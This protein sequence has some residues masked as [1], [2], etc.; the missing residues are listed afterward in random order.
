MSDQVAYER[1]Q[2]S[3]WQT[4]L[5]R[6][7]AF[8]VPGVSFQSKPS[9]EHIV[10]SAPETQTSQPRAGILVEEGPFGSGTLTLDFNPGRIEWRYAP[11]ERE[12]RVE[13]LLVEEDIP[14]IGS[15]D[16]AVEEFLAA[17]TQ[18][19]SEAR[20]DLQ[21]LAFGASILLPVETEAEGYK[22]L[23]VYL[24]NVN[25]EPPPSSDFMYQVNRLRS[26]TGSIPD[27]KINRLS[28]WSVGKY[29]RTILQVSPSIGQA[30][31]LII[32]N[33][34]RICRL[35]LDINNAPEL[36]KIIPTNKLPE[37]FRE[38]VDLGREI[39]AEGDIL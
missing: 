25:L 1:A 12:F 24:H 29:Q 23:A 15:F 11:V 38:L 8:P 33:D 5:L 6:L 32:G 34:S 28:R 27:L 4:V 31:Q 10:G 30:Q 16:H 36:N 13:D 2:L 17:A 7:T 3:E 9:W 21:R 22:R 35:E 18:W 26:S 14:S 37:L 39:A 20:L 19:L